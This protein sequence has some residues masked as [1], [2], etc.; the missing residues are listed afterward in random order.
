MALLTLQTRWDSLRQERAYMRQ[1]CADASAAMAAGPV[2]ANAVVNLAQRMRAGLANV[3]TPLVG[4]TH[5]SAYAD[6]QLVG[7]PWT[8]GALPTLLAG[9]TMLAESVIAQCRACV[10][11]DGS[12]RIL[13]DTWNSDGSVSVLQL[14]TQDTAALRT[15]LDTLVAAIPE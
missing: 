3:V 15:A 2:S 1:A 14:T 4:D 5:V 9:L 12:D 7:T 10:P 13:K 6:A 11:R 8:P